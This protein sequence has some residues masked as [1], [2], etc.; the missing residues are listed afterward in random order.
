MIGPHF[1]QMILR[2]CVFSLF[3]HSGL[4]PPERAVLQVR[5]EREAA[6]TSQGHS[7]S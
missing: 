1:S 7:A 5:V 2:L 6:G 4:R 3:H